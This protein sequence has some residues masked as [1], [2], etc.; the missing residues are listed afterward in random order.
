MGGEWEFSNEWTGTEKRERGARKEGREGGREGRASRGERGGEGAEGAGGGA[1]SLSPLRGSR[2]RYSS[3]AAAAAAPGRAALALPREVARRGREG[4]AGAVG[5]GDYSISERRIGC[6]QSQSGCKLGPWPGRVG[7]RGARGGGGGLEGQREAW[8]GLGGGP[9][10]AVV[11]ASALGFCQSTPPP[12]PGNFFSTAP[13]MD[14]NS[15]LS[16]LAYPA[17]HKE[18]SVTP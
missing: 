15:P 12:L 6:I 7:F 11:T 18:I 9:P 2:G 16:R 1:R 5:R 13:L 14:P 8:G 4:R 3:A 10:S 17:G